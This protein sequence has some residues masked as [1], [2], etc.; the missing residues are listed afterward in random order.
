MI[1]LHFFKDNLVR[2]YDFTF[3]FCIPDSVNSWEAI[4]DVPQNE[5]WQIKEYIESPYDHKSDSFYFVDDKLIMHNKAEF[6]YVH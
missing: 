1:E 4:Y 5:P 2:L 3:G 6:R